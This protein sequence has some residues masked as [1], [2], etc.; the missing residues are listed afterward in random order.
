MYPRP[1]GVLARGPIRSDGRGDPPPPVARVRTI[2]LATHSAG[3]FALGYASSAATVC[4][5]AKG[6]M[7][8]TIWARRHA[9]LSRKVG[10]PQN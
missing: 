9:V 4:K 6:D 8:R 3:E 10:Q 2:L 5:R 7:A 1:P